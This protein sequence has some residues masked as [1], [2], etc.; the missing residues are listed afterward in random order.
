VT[1]PQESLATSGRAIVVESAIDGGIDH[2]AQAR[3]IMAP[4]FWRRRLQHEQ[5]KQVPRRVHPEI[6]PADPA[7]EIIATRSG[8]RGFTLNKPNGEPQSE[9]IARSRRIIAPLA[10]GRADNP[11]IQGSTLP[12]LGIA[13]WTPIVHASETG[14]KQVLQSELK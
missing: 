3:S 10:D 8:E 6:S 4:L 11:S 13:C 2:V 7:P 1:A 12:S 14:T 5:N 9:P